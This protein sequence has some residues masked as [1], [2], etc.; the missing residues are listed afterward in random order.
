MN[1]KRSRNRFIDDSKK[2]SDKEI[3]DFLNH[4]YYELKNFDGLNELYRK[5]KELNKNIKKDDVS[6]WLKSQATHQQ[7]TI[8]KVKKK[9]FLPIYSESHYSFQIDLTFFPRYK[10]ENKNYYVLFTAINI[11]SRYAYAYYA[12]DKE[13]KNIIE[14][15]N[16]W[17]KNALIIED[18]SCDYGSEFINK[19]VKK[20]FEDHDIKTFYIKD[21]SNKLGII[22]RFHKTLKEKLN[23]YFIANDSNNWIDIIDQVIKN[24]NNT[25]NKGIYN[26]TPKEASKPFIMSELISR[27]RE[28]TENINDENDD[29]EFN[30]GDTVRVKLKHDLFDKQK[31]K[32]TDQ[33]YKIIKVNKN[34]CDVENEKYLLKSVKKYN[35][36]KINDVKN[37]KPNINRNINEK[38]NRVERLHKKIDIQPENIVQDKRNRKAKQIYDV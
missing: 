15:L 38:E 16:E 21:D 14:M 36:I 30:I 22:N 32:Y 13:Q 35:L 23:K 27:A 25:R 6:K 31:A 29:E 9:V 37:Y 28:K 17:L 33:T 12:K 4:V 10:K 5:A 2:S 19:N 1:E 3:D 11:N 26:F 8:K 34:T 18:V 24:Y 20:W 7:T